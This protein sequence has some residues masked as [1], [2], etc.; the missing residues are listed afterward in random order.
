MVKML[1]ETPIG[2]NQDVGR[3]LILFPMIISS[4]DTNLPEILFSGIYA[5][6]SPKE[7]WT[8]FSSFLKA[9]S[10]IN[11]K[12]N[13]CVWLSTALYVTGSCWEI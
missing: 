12:L 10:A 2:K 1:C 13:T 5:D 7:S 6:F 3:V 8:Y 9:I 4:R 11:E